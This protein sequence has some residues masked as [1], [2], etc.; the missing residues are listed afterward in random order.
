ML[1]GYHGKEP[2][3]SLNSIDRL[4]SVVGKVKPGTCDQIR[5]NSGN[6]NFARGSACR[7]LSGYVQSAT[8]DRSAMKL[9]LA[10][11]NSDR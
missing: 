11:M 4:I 3:R 2:Q 6:E 1:L 5:D 9:D 8:L 10:R 7:N